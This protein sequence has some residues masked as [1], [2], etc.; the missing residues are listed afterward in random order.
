ML[1]SPVMEITYLGHASFKLRGKTGTVVTDPFDSKY[2]GFDFPKVSADIV[3]VSHHHP[4]HDNLK[5]ISGTVRRPEPFII[6]APG[7]YELQDISVFGYPSFHDNKNGAE[8]GK[9]TIMVI[10][11]DGI[12]IAH[13]GDLGHTLSDQQIDN[14]GA[15]D[16]LLIGVGGDSSIGPKPAAEIIR[17]IEPSIVIP[18]HYKTEKH[19]TEPF[20]KKLPVEAF[21]KEMGKEGIEPVEKLTLV[22]TSLPEEMEIIVLKS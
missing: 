2:V 1:Y 15:I 7:E 17:N 16:V 8:R 12:R 6:D 11:A 13:L 20:A 14:L 21:L 22:S 19:T 10:A 4:D 18:M 9:N 3:T 5:A